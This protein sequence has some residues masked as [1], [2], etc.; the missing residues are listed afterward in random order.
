MHSISTFSSDPHLEQI[1][2]DYD[3]IICRS[4]AEINE[5]FRVRYKE[6]CLSRGWEDAD[7]FPEGL[8]RDHYDDNAVHIL[9]KDIVTGV[10]VGTVRIIFH[11]AAGSLEGSLPTFDLSDGFRDHLRPHMQTDRLMELSRL[12]IARETSRPVSRAD[13][14]RGIFPALALI[15]GVL[16]AISRDNVGVVVMTVARSLQRLLEKA[17]FFYNDVGIRVDHR[18]MRSPLFR[19]LT[20]LMDDLYHHNQAVWRYVTDNGAT[21]PLP[22]LLK[23]ETRLSA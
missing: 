21:W 22:A 5:C 15:K 17:G 18:G 10:S 8:E 23:P 1:L 9:L 13:L 6:Y 14:A 2:P 7:K 3:P 20:P 19:E 4:L 11:D 16:R 12:T